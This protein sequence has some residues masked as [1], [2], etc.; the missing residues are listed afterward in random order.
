MADAIDFDSATPPTQQ[1]FDAYH[2]EPVDYGEDGDQLIGWN[3]T[4]EEA[5][6]KFK[7]DWVM[8]TGDD[9]PDFDFSNS[10]IGATAVW[11]PNPDKYDGGKYCFMA[12]FAPQHPKDT[13]RF[14]KAWRL[15]V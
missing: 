5:I 10:V 7:A 1:Q 12:N 14:Y 6:E 15:W 13:I 3:Y 9:D 11:R 8:K 4:K 2:A